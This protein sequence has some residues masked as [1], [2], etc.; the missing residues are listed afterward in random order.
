MADAKSKREGKKLSQ[1]DRRAKVLTYRMSGASTR[2]IA[3]KLDCSHTTVERDI[4]ALMDEVNRHNAERAGEMH[5][6]ENARLDKLQGA[7]WVTALT[8]H[9]DSVRTVLSVMERRAKLNGL[10]KPI[11]IEAMLGESLL[12]ALSKLESVL[13]EAAYKQALEALMGTAPSES[14]LN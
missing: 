3:A 11:Q 14:L 9:P 10:D 6:L 12:Q 13:P 8:G 2:D 7:V 1:A 5:A 4:T